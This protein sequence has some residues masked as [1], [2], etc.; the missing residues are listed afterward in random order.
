MSAKK[1]KGE[2]KTVYARTKKGRRMIGRVYTRKKKYKI[3]W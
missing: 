1:L 3:E 2:R